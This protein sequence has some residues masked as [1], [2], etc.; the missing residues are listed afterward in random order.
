MNATF[1]RLCAFLAIVP[2][3]WMLCSC[4]GMFLSE[5]P[6]SAKQ[7]AQARERARRSMEISSSQ[8]AA[9]E[10]VAGVI[11]PVPCGFP[12]NHG[13]G[14]DGT[15]LPGHPNPWSIAHNDAPRGRR[16]R[17]PARERQGIPPWRPPCRP[18]ESIDPADPSG[19]SGRDDSTKAIR[20]G[21]GFLDA[22]PHRHGAQS[23]QFRHLGGLR[24]C[25]G[26]GLREA[27][28]GHNCFH[29]KDRKDPRSNCKRGHV[30]GAAPEGLT[31]SRASRDRRA[32]C[33]GRSCAGAG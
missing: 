4:T 23:R 5:E 2:P 10:P 1:L 25:T 13:P 19:F 27:F 32:E 12:G 15:A 6:Y 17:S 3:L 29:G 14:S 21:K 18:F 7:S 8:A 28:V 22:P 26:P 11:G 9:A 24:A 30:G 16:H 20:K 33:A 31:K